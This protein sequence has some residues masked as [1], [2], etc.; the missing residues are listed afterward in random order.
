M[1]TTPTSL[2]G[3]STEFEP[4]SPAMEDV[5]IFE[6]LGYVYVYV[7]VVVYVHVCRCM[8]GCM[9]HGGDVL[10]VSGR[11]ESG[12]RTDGVGILE[13][14][15][16]TMCDSCNF[17]S[18]SA[19][20]LC[21]WQ[22]IKRHGIRRCCLSSASLHLCSSSIVAPLLVPLFGHGSGRFQEVSFGG[23]G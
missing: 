2:E 7:C 17:T 15:T 8:C 5:S 9:C 20:Q 13:N 22:L 16:C 21:R 1:P 14:L 19:F 6:L 3:S 4:C 10:I 23:P 18:W 12:F 11:S